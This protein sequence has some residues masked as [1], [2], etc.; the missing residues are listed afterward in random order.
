[1][2]AEVVDLAQHRENNRLCYKCENCGSPIFIFHADNGEV[3]CGDCCDKILN[4]KVIEIDPED[5]GA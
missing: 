2:T 3:M 5:L 1:M 4:L